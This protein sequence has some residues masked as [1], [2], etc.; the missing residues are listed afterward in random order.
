MYLNKVDTKIIRLN[1]CSLNGRLKWVIIE[2][3][4]KI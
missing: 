1:N 4:E 2:N 3:I